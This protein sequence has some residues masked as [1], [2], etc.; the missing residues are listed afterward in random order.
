MCRDSHVE[1]LK[2]IEEQSH[3]AFLELKN[4]GYTVE[5]LEQLEVLERDIK[6][7]K[8]LCNNQYR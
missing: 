8:D 2:L 1:F 3:R 4:R 6:I 7:I 5:L